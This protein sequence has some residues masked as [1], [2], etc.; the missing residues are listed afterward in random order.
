MANQWDNVILQAKKQWMEASAKGDKVGMQKAHQMAEEARKKGGT[1][2]ADIDYNTAFKMVYGTPATTFEQLYQKQQP[3]ATALQKRAEE[4]IKL[5]AEAKKAALQAKLN[6]IRSKYNS[7]RREI[8]VAYSTADKDIENSM[9]ANI[10]ASDTE[11]ARRGL[12]TSSLAMNAINDIR[13]K[14]MEELARMY[15]EKNMRLTNLEEEHLTD[16][17]N[18]YDELSLLE[19]Q[20]PGLTRK[21]FNE[22]YDKAD[23]KAWARAATL[24]GWER[25]DAKT[26]YDRLYNQQKDERDYN[27]LKDR[28]LW[29][30]A[31]KEKQFNAE[32]KQQEFER[33][34]KM[35]A[36]AQEAY[37]NK[38][39]NVAE[40]SSDPMEQTV[41][42]LSHKILSRRE[43]FKSWGDFYEQIRREYL[44]GTGDFKNLSPEMK[45][46]IMAE[47]AAYKNAFEADPVSAM[48]P[49]SIWL[50]NKEIE[51]KAKQPHYVK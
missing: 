22:Y 18:I 15:L 16:E 39:R 21:L 50:K 11:A 2:G 32:Q 28:E 45:N 38:L 27:F 49:G 24:Y 35:K 23:D 33:Q 13:G 19:S 31:Y 47:I 4:E 5:E 37:L 10:Q 3:D 20:I 14:A 26:L 8:D 29:E 34:Y 40:K 25:D 48:A 36:L 1:I 46:A 12:T 42:S 51:K 41:A 17:K 7:A 43:H 6:A 30:R 9:K 44:N